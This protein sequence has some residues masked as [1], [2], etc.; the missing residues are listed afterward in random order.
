MSISR[1][2]ARVLQIVKIARGL[3]YTE[4][5]DEL[6][7]PKSSLAGYM[8]GAGNPRSDTLDMLAEKLGVPITAIVSDPL[9]GQEQA[10]TITGAAKLFAALTPEQQARGMQLFL[11]L[12]ALFAEEN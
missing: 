12:A 10:E 4:F 8:K 1:N 9:P 11:E 5:S 7:I 2:L 6:G 3:S